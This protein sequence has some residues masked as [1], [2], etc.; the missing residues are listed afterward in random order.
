MQNSMTFIFNSRRI[1]RKH[2]NVCMHAR[3][4]N[5]NKLLTLKTTLILY[6]Y[7][8]IFTVGT[9]NVAAVAAVEAR[10][11]CTSVDQLALGAKKSRRAFALFRLI[12][13]VSW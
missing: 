7:A 10:S 11:S 13:A 3:A 5:G 6:S 9:G 2:L 8:A 1:S 12:A 4:P